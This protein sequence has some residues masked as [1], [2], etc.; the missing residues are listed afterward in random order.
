[1]KRKNNI[2]NAEKS[3]ETTNAACSESIKETSQ[4]AE[5]NPTD[6][7]QSKPCYEI[8]LEMIDRNPENPRK[9]FDENKL[10]ELA[11]TIKRFGVIQPVMV[12]PVTNAETG[13]T[14]FVL[15]HGERRL[16]AS[17][18]AEKNTI[19]AFID[20]MPTEKI[21]AIA[22]LENLQ[23]V[24]I[25]EFELGSVFNKLVN[26]DKREI[27]TVA[28]EYGVSATFIRNRILLLGLIPDIRAMLDEE[29]ITISMAM[30]LC[31]YDETTQG[32]AYEQHLKPNCAGS[33]WRLLKKTEFAKKLQETYSTLLGSYSF[34]KTECG[35]C[36]Y[37]TGI[38]TEL[39]SCEGNC[40]RCLKRECLTDKNTLYLFD[41]ITQA[42][43]KDPLLAVARRG[44][45]NES[46][47]ALLKADNVEICEIDDSPRYI[48]IPKE[49]QEPRLEM[50]LKPE[51]YKAAKEQFDADSEAYRKVTAD[52][53][54]RLSD[55]QLKPYIIL[56]DKSVEYVYEDLVEAK[57]TVE[58]P[59]VTL[60]KQ[61]QQN[62]QVSR[63]KIVKSA[64]KVFQEEKVPVVNIT[65]KEE[66]Y[67]YLAMLDAIKVRFLPVLNI[68]KLGD[69]ASDVD[70]L[71]VVNRLTAKQKI[72]IKRV[73]LM[74]ALS[75]AI[76]ESP[77]YVIFEEF[78][79]TFYPE[80]FKEVAQKHMEQYTKQHDT[81]EAKIAEIKNEQ[82]EDTAK[83]QEEPA[84]ENAPGG[85][86]QPTP[87]VEDAPI[88]EP[89]PESVPATTDDPQ[90]VE[91]PLPVEPTPDRTNPDPVENQPEEP[92]QMQPEEM[93]DTELDPWEK[94]LIEGEEPA[95]E[96]PFDPVEEAEPQFAEFQTGKS[97]KNPK[98]NSKQVAA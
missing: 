74:S 54:W 21:E 23:R 22:V 29:A 73:F 71:A 38:Q 45:A 36:P 52:I 32:D 95:E 40:A 46:V 79:Q 98:R 31:K 97:H 60:K 94:I 89:E 5:T 6:K 82:K 48:S 7:M 18:I 20:E 35:S 13:E 90:E 9:H 62:L 37:N 76:P 34:D 59:V 65:D 83:E 39:F 80:Q 28:D 88:A 26:H 30:E 14:R 87:A 47:L 92:D 16:R 75:S 33:S 78:A 19:P 49:P 63:E 85:E 58:N 11:E 70:K 27:G 66:K 56:R 3:N 69:K 43:E 24:D 91:T 84:T 81:I 15:V 68:K 4:V 55:G 42:R 53:A 96:N 17:M 67:L 12:N 25:S 1:M 50:F 41:V 2:G 86:A 51:D 57:K 44:E 8:P 77:R 10:K 61:D 64:I 72:L 93:P